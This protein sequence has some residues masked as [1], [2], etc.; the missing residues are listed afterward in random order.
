MG[1]EK[2]A[3]LSKS[4]LWNDYDTPSHALRVLYQTVGSNKKWKDGTLDKH[5]KVTV[6]A[7]SCCKTWRNARRLQVWSSERFPEE[8]K[9]G[10]NEDYFATVSC[11]NDAYTVANSK[12]MTFQN[13][14]ALWKCRCNSHPDQSIWGMA[15]FRSPPPLFVFLFSLSTFAD[16]K[17][18]WRFKSELGENGN[19]DGTSMTQVRTSILFSDTIY[20]FLLPRNVYLPRK[21]LLPRN[22]LI[23]GKFISKGLQRCRQSSG[24]KK[25]WKKLSNG[26][27]TTPSWCA[28]MI[29]S[30]DFRTARKNTYKYPPG[31]Q[32][33]GVVKE[34]LSQSNP[35]H[36]YHSP[37]LYSTPKSL[38]LSNL[39]ALSPVCQSE[40]QICA[41]RVRRRPAPPKR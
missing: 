27:Y 7:N 37:R 5:W 4:K 17:N 33:A 38:A 36:R 12:R 21:P 41:R 31:D 25:S 14:K 28:S 32:S 22:V 16:Y 9:R 3:T 30:W 1:D 2:W 13:S 15:Q 26:V 34:E 8:T 18:F 24:I 19:V 20:L 40:M 23:L 10:S 35:G 39:R 11:I 29:H 6:L